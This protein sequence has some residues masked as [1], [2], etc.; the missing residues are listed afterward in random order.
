MYTNRE[1]NKSWAQRNRNWWKLRKNRNILELLCTLH[2]RGY[3]LEKVQRKL[4]NFSYVD[5]L[6]P[7]KRTLDPLVTTATCWVVLL[8]THDRCILPLQH[9]HLLCCES[10]DGVLVLWGRT[11]HELLLFFNPAGPQTASGQYPSGVWLRGFLVDLKVSNISN[12]AFLLIL[13]SR[14]CNSF[15]TASFAWLWCKSIQWQKYKTSAK[16]SDAR[17]VKTMPLTWW[18]T[19]VEPG[20]WDPDRPIKTA[21]ETVLIWLLFLLSAGSA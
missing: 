6:T 15:L 8:L 5:N 17:K 14:S 4:Y 18:Q 13:T 21:A 20:G 2:M 3:G 19:N 10:A 16:S 11:S 7:T 1:V 9:V 12:S